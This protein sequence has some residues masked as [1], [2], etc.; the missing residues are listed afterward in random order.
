MPLDSS[1]EGANLHGSLTT[2]NGEGVAPYT[3]IHPADAANIVN[4]YN[5]YQGGR[6]CTP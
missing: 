6:L 3:D 4:G 2:E 1:L 5:A